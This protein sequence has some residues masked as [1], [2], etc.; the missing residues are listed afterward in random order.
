M[1]NENTPAVEDDLPEQLRIR[2]E[3]RAGLLERGV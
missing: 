3:K 1:T 2:R